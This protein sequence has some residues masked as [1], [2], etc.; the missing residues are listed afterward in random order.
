MSSPTAL[1]ALQ[2]VS[3]YISRCV[4]LHLACKDG[5][6]N[7]FITTVYSLPKGSLFI[8]LHNSLWA[9]LLFDLITTSSLFEA[10]W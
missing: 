5:P 1:D 4:R 7:V 9:V 3:H 2:I 10:C 6:L 8:W